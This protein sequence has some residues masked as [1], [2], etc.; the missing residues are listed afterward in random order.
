MQR[1]FTLI[2]MLTVIALIALLT[3]ILLPAY[4]IIREKSRQ[5]DCMGNLKSI[6]LALK[7]YAQDHDGVNTLSLARGVFGGQCAFFG[8]YAHI[9][10]PYTRSKIVYACPSQ[11]F[12]LLRSGN[13]V[14]GVVPLDISYAI[15]ANND[16]AFQDDCL[17]APS[18]RSPAFAGV[19][20]TRI[21]DPDNRLALLDAPT[22]ENPTGTPPNGWRLFHPTED[23]CR[24]PNLL[25]GWLQKAA[26]HSRGANFL[27]ADGHVQWFE[28][29]Q[30]LA[31]ATQNPWLSNPCP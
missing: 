27:F 7:G 5:S 29:A 3:G 2:E 28:R 6:G 23:F 25:D 14:L 8:L 18:L 4:F 13:P 21:A 19:A 20:L 17:I 11:P 26:R 9:L 12:P 24:R 30:A 15:N 31:N 22:A 1:G 10:L 16:D